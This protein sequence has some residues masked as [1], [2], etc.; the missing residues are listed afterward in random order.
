MKVVKFGLLSLIVIVLSACG[1]PKMPI[2][3]ESES[4]ALFSVLK[5]VDPSKHEHI[6]SVRVYLNGYICPTCIAPIK[7]TL[8]ME[9]GVKIVAEHPEIGMIEI[10]TE[11]DKFIDLRNIR[12]RVNGTRV[13]TVRKMEVVAAGRVVKLTQQ[14]HSNTP[15]AHFHDWYR[16]IVDKDDPDHAFVLTE[17]KKLEELKAS[18]YERIVAI[19]TVTSFFD[20][21]P[22]LSITEFMELKEP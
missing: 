16:L 13:L 22:I 11:G 3:V 12:E 15:H 14:Y 21:F 2:E 17:G 9:E 5:T 20:S 8:E 4:E 10:I 7:R 18:G 6:E 19:G 1:A